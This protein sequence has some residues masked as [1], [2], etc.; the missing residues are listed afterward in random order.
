MLLNETERVGNAEKVELIVACIV[1][2]NYKQF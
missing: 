2:L 1:I